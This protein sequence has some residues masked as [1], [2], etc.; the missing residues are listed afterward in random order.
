[1]PKRVMEPEGATQ[2]GYSLLGLLHLYHDYVLWNKESADKDPPTGSH[3]Q[4]RLVRVPLSLISHVQ[5]LAEVAAR[6][7]GG[8]IGKWRLIVWVE[9]AKS[10]LR[11]VLLTNDVAV[12]LRA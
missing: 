9:G 1:M 5:V 11:L 6:R 8:D 10:V 12:T 7:V 2:F 3:K 4:T